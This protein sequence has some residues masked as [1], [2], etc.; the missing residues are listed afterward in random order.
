MIFRATLK[1]FKLLKFDDGMKMPLRRVMSAWSKSFI[2]HTSCSST[3]SKK[4]CCAIA[5]AVFP[6]ILPIQIVQ[7]VQLSTNLLYKM[8]P[9]VDLVCSYVIAQTALDELD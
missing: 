8:V 2:L 9:L 3:H 6:Q 1:W 4:I 5:E 7:G